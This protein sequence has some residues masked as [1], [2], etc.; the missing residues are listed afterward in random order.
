MFKS[1]WVPWFIAGLVFIV[2]CTGLMAAISS[3]DPAETGV[4]NP[5]DSPTEVAQPIPTPTSIW[6]PT[7]TPGGIATPTAQVAP[8]PTTRPAVAPA[9]PPPGALTRLI[10]S[11][12]PE[13]ISAQVKYEEYDTNDPFRSITIRLQMNEPPELAQEVAGEAIRLVRWQVEGAGSLDASQWQYIALVFRPEETEPFIVGVKRP[14]RNY[15][16]WD[17]LGTGAGEPDS[18]PMPTDFKSLAVHE[19]KR[20]PRVRD[21]SVALDGRTLSL[22]IIVEYATNESYAKQLGD[23]FVRLVKTFSDDDPPGQKIGRGTYDYLVGVYYPNEKRL[24]LGAK[25]R[26]ADHISW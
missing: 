17:P 23:N 10:E 24:V 12:F 11:S 6:I 18:A 21:A 2:G 14:M 9:P 5:L 7:R 4:E 20:S 8:T 22:V 1:D 13:A 15:I 16:E 26:A 3:E 19:I 25:S